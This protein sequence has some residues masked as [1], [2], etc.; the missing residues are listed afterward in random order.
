MLDWT[1]IGSRRRSWSANTPPPNSEKSAVPITISKG[2]ALTGLE[3]MV[4][5]FITMGLD[6]SDKNIIN[7]LVGEELLRNIKDEV[8]H[9]AALTASIEAMSN[10]DDSFESEAVHIIKSWSELPDNP[11]TIAACL[12]N[13]VFFVLLPL[14]RLY[15][16]T[17]LAITANSISGDELIHVQTHRAV[18]QML[19]AKP[20]KQLLQLV[21]DTVEWVTSSIDEET[22]LLAKPMTLERCLKNS[23]SLL[24]KGVSDL[25]ETRSGAYLAPYEV[26]N[27]SIDSYAA[28]A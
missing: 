11:I 7:G 3:P 27:T 2:L 25:I 12:E 5:D 8:N 15:G 1:T 16:S 17:C 26:P 23:R 28:V 19:K 14:Y 10:Y 24:T 22:A 9:E 13:G 4:A 18:A 6:R 20:S 21:L